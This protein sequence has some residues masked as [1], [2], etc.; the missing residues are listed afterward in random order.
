MWSSAAETVPRTAASL[1]VLLGFS[2]TEFA[3]LSHW[4]PIELEGCT[5][6]FGGCFY[7]YAMD[8]G[9]S[10]LRHLGGRGVEARLD[11]NCFWRGF[12]F[13]RKG[14]DDSGRSA[15]VLVL[16]KPIVAEHRRASILTYF[17]YSA[18]H[19]S[20]QS[21]MRIWHVRNVSFFG[22]D[23][24]SGSRIESDQ[25]SSPTFDAG[26]RRKWPSLVRELGTYPTPQC[27]GLESGRPFGMDQ[28][29]SR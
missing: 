17:V 25:L 8:M 11:P 28:R 13:C 20:L 3:K 4:K 9:I 15:V 27:L 10:K 1:L 16:R 24:K 14:E 21:E 29:A 19:I 12:F 5:A 6:R 22:D 23:E 2:C 7:E 26:L 18:S